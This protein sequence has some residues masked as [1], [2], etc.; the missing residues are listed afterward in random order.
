VHV[1]DREVFR[2][3]TMALHLLTV[4]RQMS[5]AAWAWNPHFER[6]AGS[7]WVRSALETGKSVS[8]IQSRWTASS[9]GFVHQKEK[10]LLY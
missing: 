10:Y 2:P 4:T 8:E 9:A 3:V 1:I 6:L 5:G 7:S